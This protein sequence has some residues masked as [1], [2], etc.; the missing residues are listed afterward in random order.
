MSAY[1]FALLWT[2]CVVPYGE[3]PEP[4]ASSAVASAANATGADLSGLEARILMLIE[5]NQDA[6]RARRLSAARQLLRKGRGWAP[7][8]Q[9][10]LVTYLNALLDVEERYHVEESMGVAVPLAGAIQE[11]TALDGETALPAPGAGALAQPMAEEELGGDDSDLPGTEPAEDELAEDPSSDAELALAPARQALADGRY[12]EAIQALDELGSDSEEAQELHR[13][14]VDDYVHL[15]RERAGRLFLEARSAEA[16]DA[17]LGKLG[18]VKEVLQRL[19][20]EF[21]DNS[22]AG[23]I[24]RNLQ[25]VERELDRGL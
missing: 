24:S 13:E 10:D 20:D 7:E 21:P 11:Q 1:V 5:E 15:E 2:A 25:L 14:A 9:R 16:E 8:A 12:L 18:E 6:D 17:R 22:Y 4:L 3:A 19:L 23:A